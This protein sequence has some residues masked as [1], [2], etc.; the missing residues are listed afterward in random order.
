MI[1]QTYPARDARAAFDLI[2]QHPEQTIK[3]HLDFS[4]QPRR[5]LFRSCR[6]GGDGD[7]GRKQIWRKR[8]M[9]TR[10]ISRHTFAGGFAAASALTTF[11]AP[12]IAQR[13]KYR[14]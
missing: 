8:S 12:A 14:L 9:T 11:G 2:E 5:R 4:W 7:D 1:T 3:V 6:C 10:T 13:A